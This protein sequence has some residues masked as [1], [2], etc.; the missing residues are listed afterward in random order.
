M[1]ESSPRT[2]N[3]RDALHMLGMT[4]A[5]AAFPARASA[6]T[7]GFPKGAVI[8]TILKDYAPEDL[9]GGV[10]LF[11]EH[12][13]LATDFGARFNAATAAVRAANGLPARG[14]GDG[15]GGAAPAGAGAG[16]AAGAAPAG[17][18]PMRDADPM[19]EEP[20]LPHR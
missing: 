4:A 8:R 15:A 18:A 2:F 14:R 10:T 7:P 5:A 6:Q 20:R 17:P 3:R 1:S 13:S 16:R 12:M 9:S 11:H 19:A